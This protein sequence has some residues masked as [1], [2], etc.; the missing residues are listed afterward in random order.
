MRGSAARLSGTVKGA[1]AGQVRLTVERERGGRWVVARRV[2]ATVK[3]SGSFYKDIPR[4]SRGTYRLRGSFLGT[5]TSEPVALRVQG[6]H[7]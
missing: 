5:G 6:F 4:L 2:E 7:A 3:R 1:V